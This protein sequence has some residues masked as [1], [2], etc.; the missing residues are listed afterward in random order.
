MS[1]ILD[2]LKKLD[3]EKFFRKNMA[4]NIAVDILKPDL[5]R[6]KKRFPRYVATIL[7]TA[8][9]VAV[10]TYFIMSHFLPKSLPPPPMESSAP[11]QRVIPPPT[12]FHLPSKSSVSGTVNPPV[13]IQ[14]VTPAPVLRE[15]HQVVQDEIKRRSAKPPTPAKEKIPIESK[16]IAENIP[17]DTS[18]DEKKEKPNM[19]REE[20]EVPFSN[21]KKIP[22]Q[23]AAVSTTNPPSLKLTTIVWYEEPSM[24]FI[25]VNGIKASEGSIVEGVKVVEIKPTCVRF[26]FNDQYFEISM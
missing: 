8:M 17:A 11:R 20:A 22:E 5:P 25:M 3:R 26:L 19:I 1:V 10:I 4:T 7:L 21:I 24:R 12:E 2:A 14:Q 23:S 6:N 15:D 13:S 16:P 18:V 9:A